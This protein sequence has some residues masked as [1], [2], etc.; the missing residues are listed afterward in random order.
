MNVSRNIN[1]IFRL[2]VYANSQFRF[3]P[4]D[5]LLCPLK[6]HHFT[7]FNIEFDKS[8]P[9]ITDYRVQRNSLHGSCSRIHIRGRTAEIDPQLFLPVPQSTLMPLK[10]LNIS[11]L[12][13]LFI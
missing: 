7:S 11:F 12:E 9:L 13:C 5:R 3:V 2:V 6:G 10:V 4:Q 1:D 8:D